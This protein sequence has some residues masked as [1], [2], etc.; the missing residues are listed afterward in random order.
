MRCDAERESPPVRVGLRI[1]QQPVLAGLADGGL[2]VRHE[3]DDPGPSAAPWGQA[4][5]RASSML[6]L[7]MAC[8][9]S[10][11]ARLQ[12]GVVGRR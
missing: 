3:D 4:S 9:P 1:F 6:V 12:A 2:A 7:P 5:A 11:K 8:R 10:M